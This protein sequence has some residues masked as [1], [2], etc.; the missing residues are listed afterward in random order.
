MTVEMVCEVGALT[1][2][3]DIKAAECGGVDGAHTNIVGAGE[4]FVGA[5]S[6][7]VNR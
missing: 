5:V 2:M 6:S 4:A 7:G 3:G 1:T